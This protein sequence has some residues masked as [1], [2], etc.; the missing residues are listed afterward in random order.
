MPRTRESVPSSPAP[1][2]FFSSFAALRAV[3][4]QPLLRS[5][6][7]CWPLSV[8]PQGPGGR[9]WLWSSPGLTVKTHHPERGPAEASAQLRPACRAAGS[10]PRA[11]VT[12]WRLSLFRLSP[13]PPPTARVPGKTSSVGRGLLLLLES[14]ELSFVE[15]LLSVRDCTKPFMGICSFN[16]L[17]NLPWQVC[18]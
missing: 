4:F 17:N 3:E 8:G 1:S 9:R 13:A 10:C 12:G 14:L 18:L 11:L 6:A 5:I 7:H 2:S 15:H 16:P